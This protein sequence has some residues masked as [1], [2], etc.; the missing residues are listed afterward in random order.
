MTPSFTS[1]LTCDARVHTDYAGTD[2]WYAYTGLGIIDDSLV[3]P[4][5]LARTAQNLYG[6]LRRQFFSR[7]RTTLKK[8][9]R[10]QNAVGRDRGVFLGGELHYAIKGLPS[11]YD[12]L[13]VG[14]IA[15]PGGRHVAFFSVR[16][17]DTPKTTLD[18]L[19]RSIETLA[20]R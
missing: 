18:A 9:G 14:L 16:P 20:A 15:L 8:F 5:D 11:R 1:A 3:A 6:S 19:N 10:L 17:D 12:R 2:D 13:V 7:Q 4:G